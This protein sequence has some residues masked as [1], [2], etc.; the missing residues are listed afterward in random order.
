MKTDAELKVDVLAELAWD[1]V[2]N[3]AAVGVIVKD[4]LVTLTGHLDT[5]AQKHAAERAVRRVAGVRGIAVELDV[6]LAPEHRRSDSDIAQAAIA[7]L[8]WN[9]LVPD[10]HVK[11]EVEDAWVTL[12]G[13][14]DWPYQ[15]SSAE[16]CIRPLTGVRGVTNLVKLKPHVRGNDIARQITAAL[17]RHA[18]REAQHI[19]VEVVEG[20][21]TLSGRVDSLAEHDAAIGAAFGTRGVTS[22]IDKLD[23][24]L[25]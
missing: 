15:L 13:E 11:V 17:T 3:A 21:V 7:A 18:E 12:T 14:V 4:G 24:K 2:L 6:K 25:T 16:Q 1:P 9:S 10:E 8:R 19:D 5:F 23:V 20:A 22:V